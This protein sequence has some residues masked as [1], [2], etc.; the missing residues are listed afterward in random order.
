MPV[1]TCQSNTNAH[2]GDI[3]WLA[4]QKKCTKQQIKDNKAK[5]KAAK[6][7][8]ARERHAVISSIAGLKA[9]ADHKEEVIRAH[10]SRP[11]LLYCSSNATRTTAALIL[12]NRV[13]VRAWKYTK[14]AHGSAV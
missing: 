4:K 10:A 3:V 12:E 11:D 14:T 8:A 6:Q 7:E 5:A 1:V 9:T 13:P 2:P